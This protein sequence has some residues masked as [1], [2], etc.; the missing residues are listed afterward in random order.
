MRKTFTK[1]TFT[2]DQK[3]KWA[4]TWNMG[5]GGHRGQHLLIQTDGQKERGR[6]QTSFSQKCFEKQ[7][8]NVHDFGERSSNYP[9]K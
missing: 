5:E 6:G 8:K 9:W 1:E 7:S 3:G 4:D 2:H